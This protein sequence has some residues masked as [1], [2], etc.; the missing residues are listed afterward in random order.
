M[1][2]EYVE[3]GIPFLRS[4][5]V[6]PYTY[7]AEDLKYIS[8][9]FHQKISKS[10]LRPGDVVAVRTGNPGASFVVPKS[11]PEANCSD[12]VIIRCGKKLDPYFVSY[13]IN[14]VTHSQ[15]HS[16][17]VGAVQKHF[18][19]GSAKEILIPDIS[20]SDQQKIAAVLSALDA[21]IELNKRINAELEAM[22]K[23]LYDYWFVQFDFPCPEDVARAQGRPELAGKPYKSSGGRMVWSPEL[24]RDI[25]EGW[26]V[27]TLSSVV[28]LVKCNV[29]P[30]EIGT[31]T[32]Y[33]GLEHIG[34]KTIVLS[35][36][37]TSESA[38]SNKIAFQEKD[39]LFGK[40]RPY[41][42]KVAV[43]PFS[44]IA[45]TDTIILRT[46]DQ[47][48]HGY[49]VEI[50]FSEK[51]VEAAVQSSSGSKMP[52]A[53]WNVLKDFVVPF[54]KMS[55]IEAYQ[56]HFSKCLEKIFENVK[57]NKNLASLRDF[58]LPLLMNGQVTVE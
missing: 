46:R 39:I 36:W 30:S 41:F 1:A 31:E 38:N 21:K 33:V 3:N 54:P 19:I 32:P 57:E 4:L 13:F 42:H 8:P 40:I 22:A 7:I 55:L 10:K 35:E 5:N 58:L 52:R 12:L 34:R 23:T 17:L 9:E 50:V 47:K 37:A 45:S 43:S 25:P 44:G 48:M 16:Q 29:S 11:L 56:E 51:F 20:L 24:K 49:T 28:S 6:K 15:V 26:G 18:N 14:S 53:D 27:G 2:D